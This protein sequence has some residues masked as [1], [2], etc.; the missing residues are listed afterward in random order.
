MSPRP[1]KP[2]SK[3]FDNEPHDPH[4]YYHG[5][6]DVDCL[7][8][9]PLRDP[10][11]DDAETPEEFFGL[12][13]VTKASGFMWGSVVPGEL[14]E[15]TPLIQDYDPELERLLWE[16]ER[17]E[18]ELAHGLNIRRHADDGVPPEEIAEIFNVD[19]KIIHMILDASKSTKPYTESDESLSDESECTRFDQ[20]LDWWESRHQLSRDLMTVVFY[21]IAF[22]SLAFIVY[23]ITG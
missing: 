9:S 2:C 12:D 19:I 21:L 5:G 15:K 11:S 17:I 20:I 8:Y 4:T 7:G 18:T 6:Q 10:K 22:T 3:V 14:Q 23:N 13:P 16:E 1:L